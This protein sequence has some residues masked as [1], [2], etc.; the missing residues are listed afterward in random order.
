MYS[1]T[2]DKGEADRWGLM[3]F[4]EPADVDGTGLL[5]ID[6]PGD[7]SDQWIYLPALD[8]VRRISSRRKGGRFVGSEFYYEDLSDREV[9]MDSHEILGKDKVGGIECTLL[10]STPVK[11]SNSVY[12]KRIACIH[13]G[14]MI[15]L[16]VDFYKKGK[17][18]IKRLQAS[19]IKK[20]Q[21][22]WTIFDSTM[23]N[24]K[25]GASTK[26]LTSSI[27]YDRKLPESLFSQ[28]G[29]SDQ[30]IERSFRLPAND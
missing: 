8:K 14:L 24:L 19:K 30:T 18:P 29:L 26:L 17:R 10:Q 22:Y 11:R 7:D 16:R 2:L 27:A 23:Y 12:S 5:T 15:P 1:Y 6:H 28:R 4:I 20:V 21:G 13:T 25:T 3:R 9:S